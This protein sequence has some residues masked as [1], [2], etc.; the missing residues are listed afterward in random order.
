[1]KILIT[2]GSGFIG[3]RLVN[4]IANSGNHEIY[5]IDK[6]SYASNEELN[7]N[8]YD[9]YNL[10]ELDLCNE[11]KLNKIIKSINPEIVYHLA[12]ETHVDNSILSPKEFINSNILGTYNLL[13]ALKSSNQNQP[14]RLKKFIHISTDEVF[15]DNI[16]HAS[17]NHKY[18]PSSP[19]SASKASSDMLVMAW[20]RTFSIPVILT[21]CSNNYGPNQNKE[22]F[23][24]KTIDSFL[25]HKTIPVYGDGQ[26]TRDW[27][28]VD[29]HIKALCLIAEQGKIGSRYNISTMENYTNME[30]I[31]LI[32]KII[33]DLN[34]GHKSGNPKK[35]DLIEYV[36]DRPGHDINYKLDSTKIRKELKWSPE[37]FLSC[38]LETTIRWYM[39]NHIK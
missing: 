20:Q 24:P 25:N 21:N 38:N 8:R 15:G 7:A 29:D 6:L 22:K 33:N 34:P 12:A 9:N 27:L 3:S 18:L 1:M 30:I 36:Q 13:E 37:S 32:E 10:F 11:E 16:D 4:Y 19:Y 35:E 28:Y 31:C 39:N 5:N 23:I 2:G 26:Q 14:S 17:E